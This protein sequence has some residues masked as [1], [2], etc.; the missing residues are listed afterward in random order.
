[1]IKLM[2]HVP[3]LND[4]GTRSPDDETCQSVH[5]NCRVHSRSLVVG[6]ARRLLSRLARP[7]R[8]VDPHSV[9]TDRSRDGAFVAAPSIAERTQFMP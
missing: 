4:F 9:G 7:A 3:H 8:P 2:H 6:S 5:A 1:M